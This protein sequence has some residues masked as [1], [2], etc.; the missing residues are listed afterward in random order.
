[1][2]GKSAK[3][4]PLSPMKYQTNL[5]KRKMSM[6]GY[7]SMVMSRLKFKSFLMMVCLN[8]GCFWQMVSICSLYF[9]YP[10][11]IFIDT[12]FDVFEQTVPALTFCTSVGQ[13][14]RGKNT[15]T[16]LFDNF[17]LNTTIEQI[18]INSLADQVDIITDQYLSSVIESVS[19]NYYCFT[20]NSQVKGKS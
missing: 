11:N 15:S 9:N 14:H 18:S 10:T 6:D 17:S 5:P 1:M 8:I 2:S 13:T 19:I 20:L 3:N 7:V 12:K 4:D 16:H